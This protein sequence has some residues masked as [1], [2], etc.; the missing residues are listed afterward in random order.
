[1]KKKTHYISKKDKDQ[2]SLVEEPLMVY[3]PLRML[4]SL[5][6]FTYYEFKKIS[7]KA[8]FNQS[9]WASFLHVSERTLQRYAKGE[10]S[11]AAIN[12]ERAM[13]VAGVLEVGKNIFGTTAQFYTWLKSNPPML[14]GVLSLESLTSAHGIQ[15]VLI[16][17]GRIQH[18]ILA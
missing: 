8:P 6:D 4:P 12:A 7:D 17:L 18:G 11:F 10:G 2:P 3:N 16:Q 13:Q 1:M 5:K 9:E 14:E 15:M